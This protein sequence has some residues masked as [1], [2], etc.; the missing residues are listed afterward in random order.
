MRQQMF[1]SLFRKGNKNIEAQE[2]ALEI[3]RTTLMNR[4][5]QILERSTTVQAKFTSLTGVRPLHN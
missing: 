4:V 1:S 3:A 5:D 2:Q